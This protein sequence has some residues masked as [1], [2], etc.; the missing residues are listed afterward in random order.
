MAALPEISAKWS[1][2][3]DL[4]GENVL[5]TGASG[6]L[7]LAVA[8]QIAE[9]GGNLIL[10]VRNVRKASALAK[11]L[12][13]ASRGSIDVIELDLSDLK[14][15]H[16]AAEQVKNKIDI[17][18][19]NAGVMATP[20]R[21]TVDGFELQ[22]VTNHLG[23]FAF[24][25]LLQNKL[26]EGARVVS[27]ASQAHRLAQFPAAKI[28]DICRG[29]GEYQPWQAYARSKVSNLLFIN[30][31]QRRNSKSKKVIAVSAHPGW[32]ATNLQMVGPQMRN[33]LM[34]ARGSAFFNSAF[35]QSADKGALP[36]LCAATLVDL[37]GGSYLGPNGFLEM[38]GYPKYTR[39]SS[40]A[41]DQGL[42]QSLWQ[43]S[44]ELTGVTWK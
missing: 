20:L 10:A 13:I 12:S 37:P 4:T 8:K 25:G 43:I 33:Q 21:H 6:G 9:H 31:L 24:T 16:S 5:I 38:R 11:Q 17:L 22:M 3:R 18:I 32:S 44:E 27:V 36:I 1:K 15:V 26:K 41:Y 40:T 39:A 19:L 2:P 42:A 7:G 34:M 29:V 14:S 30:E 28:M 35:A 23:H